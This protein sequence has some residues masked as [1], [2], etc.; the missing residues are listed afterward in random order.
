[1]T[2]SPA[3][4]A[5]P[6]SRLHLNAVATLSHRVREELHRGLAAFPYIYE[7]KTLSLFQDR[8]IARPQDRKPVRR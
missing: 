2:E 3:T 8:N 4:S 5:W 6:S 1:M 7:K